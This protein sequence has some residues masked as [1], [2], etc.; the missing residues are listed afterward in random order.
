[1]KSYLFAYGALTNASVMADRCPTAE[2]VGR[3][4]LHGYRLVFRYVADIQRV[5]GG[6]VSGILWKINAKCVSVLDHYEG[7]PRHYA[8]RRVD[9]LHDELGQVE[10]KIYVLEGR[11]HQEPPRAAYRDTIAHGYR[12]HDISIKQL[13]MA[14]REAER[15]NNEEI[16]EIRKVEYDYSSDEGKM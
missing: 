11:A 6:V 1:M 16:W 2:L 13:N 14:L 12:E 8:K 4:D 15:V 5:E 10:A 9:A 7:F 3:A